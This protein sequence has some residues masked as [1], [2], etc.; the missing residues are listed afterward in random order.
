MPPSICFIISMPKVCEIMEINELLFA[1]HSWKGLDFHIL[2]N[3]YLISP[4]QLIIHLIFLK[5]SF[6]ENQINI[7]DFTPVYYCATILS[8]HFI[9]V[10]VRVFLNNKRQHCDLF[11]R[12]S[13]KIRAIVLVQ[14]HK[15]WEEI[16]CTIDHAHE[17]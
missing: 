13:Q 7:H 8:I 6:L 9:Q 4:L 12:S 16:L 2:R 14:V 15:H 10:S 11:H 17:V 5:V 1:H 3:V